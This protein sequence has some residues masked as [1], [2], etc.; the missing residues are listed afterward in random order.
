MK[1]RDYFGFEK[2]IFFTYPSKKISSRL[3]YVTDKPTTKK[4]S[5]VLHSH[6]TYLHIL[7]VRCKTYVEYP[8]P[9]NVCHIKKMEWNAVPWLFFSSGMEVIWAEKNFFYLINLNTE[10]E[11][12]NKT[13]NISLIFSFFLFHKILLFITKLWLCFK[14]HHPI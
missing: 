1:L 2:T 3:Y 5:S 13:W 10:T 11:G 9:F 4:C 14:K 8:I 12:E 7:I 6:V